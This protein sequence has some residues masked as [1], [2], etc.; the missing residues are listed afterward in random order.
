MFPVG[1]KTKKKTSPQ[2]TE[3]VLQEGGDEEDG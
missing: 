2:V 1:S 3:T